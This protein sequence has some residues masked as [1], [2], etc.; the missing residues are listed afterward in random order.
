MTQRVLTGGLR[1]QAMI[2]WDAMTCEQIATL[3]LE[4]NGRSAAISA[5]EKWIAVYALDF[6]PDGKTL[7]SGSLDRTVKLWNVPTGSLLFTLNDHQDHVRAV[8]FSRDGQYLATGSANGEIVIYRAAPNEK[9][10]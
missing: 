2:I 1:E 7:A 8:R 4:H 6:S 5:D 9:K 10:G 3:D